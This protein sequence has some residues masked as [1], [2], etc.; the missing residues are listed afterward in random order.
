MISHTRNRESRPIRRWR[1]RQA[2]KTPTPREGAPFLLLC[3][4][5]DAR[6]SGFWSAVEVDTLESIAL[7]GWV[8]G[9]R[10]AASSGAA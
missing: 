10:Y 9:H 1:A 2:A 8:L 4:C 6:G 5:E 3:R 7:A